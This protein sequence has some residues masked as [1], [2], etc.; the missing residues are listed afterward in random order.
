VLL[1]ALTN[2]VLYCALLPLWEGFDEPFHYGYIETLVV[3]H[4]LPVL[5]Q[6][7][8]STEIRQSLMATP[9]PRFLKVVVRGSSVAI[10][11]WSALLAP[12]R[13]LRGDALRTIPRT[14][15]YKRSTFFNYEAQQAPLAY[16]LLM[17]ID[18][19]FAPLPLPSRILALRL[20]V[21]LVCTALAFF[22]LNDLCA[23]LGVTRFFRLAALAFVF[24][25]EMFWATVAHV[26]NDWLAVSIAIAFVAVLIRLI[27][28]PE[29]RNALGLGVLLACG[30][31]AKAYFLAFVPVFVA[32]LAY[33]TLR[34]RLSTKLMAV[35]MVIPLVIAGPWYARNI[36]LY[37]N[38]GGTQEAARGSGPR[39]AISALGKIDWRASA[40][41]TAHWGLWT[42]NWSFLAFSRTT[43]NIEI[44]LLA[45][46]AVLFFWRWRRV[47]P[48]EWWV[49]AMFACFGA[50]LVYQQC[51]AW[52][53]TGGRSNAAEPWY[54]QSV[55]PSIFVLLFA[56]LE[57]SGMLGRAVAICLC[58]VGAWIAAVTYVAKLLPFY[59]GYRGPSTL[60]GVVHWWSNAPATALR[61]ITLV[62]VP[63]VFALTGVFLALLI[64][65]TAVL[66]RFSR[67]NVS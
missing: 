30:L 40:A 1:L 21:A 52:V 45:I 39:A 61:G 13:R 19:I 22:L 62:P 32:L 3:E 43:L 15:R 38:L 6:T 17:P 59:G 5:G 65:V 56:G 60:A 33:L 9:I 53:D 35:S 63:V 29:S 16:I 27:S 41:Q 46:A 24:E 55:L 42:G 12:E 14:L 10:E 36:A 2:A 31:A 25:A 54:S 23:A 7:T 18:V 34:R 37:G 64:G 57:R 49:L 51:V 28:A 11:D 66:L 20:V 4:R 47:T 44:T 26:A 67:M 8:I 48:G 58:L 50:A